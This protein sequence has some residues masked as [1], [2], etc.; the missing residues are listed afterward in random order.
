MPFLHHP[1]LSSHTKPN[2]LIILIWH[3]LSL[4]QEWGQC[5]KAIA[6]GDVVWIPPEVK[7]WHGAASNETMTHVAIA[8][9]Q[10]GKS[11]TWMEKVTDT[12]YADAVSGQK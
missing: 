10:N 12:Q 1:N 11:V 9:G 2:A 6:L 5:A 4:V 7:H 8:E 3:A